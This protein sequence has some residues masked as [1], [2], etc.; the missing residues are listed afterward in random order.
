M[1]KSS[2]TTLSWLLFIISTV[3][4]LLML[5][6]VPQWFWVALPF[7]LTYLVQAMRLM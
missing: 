6:W 4:M 5:V 1:E 7:S 2:N 3:I